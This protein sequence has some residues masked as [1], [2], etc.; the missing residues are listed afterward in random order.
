[1]DIL[2]HY[3]QSRIPPAADLNLRDVRVSHVRPELANVWGVLF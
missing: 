2:A 1:M 3:V